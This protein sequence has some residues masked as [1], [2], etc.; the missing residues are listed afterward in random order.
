MGLD[1]TPGRIAMSLQRRMQAYGETPEMLAAE[2]A[3]CYAC[4]AKNPN[5]KN[6]K[7]FS[8]AK[9]LASPVLFLA[10]PQAACITGQSLGVSGGF[11]MQ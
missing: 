2:A 7:A 3:Q 8:A 6:R 4:G 9:I 11:H 10:S 5:A 1:V